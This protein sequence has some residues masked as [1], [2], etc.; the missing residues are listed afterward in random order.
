M[1]PARRPF[2]PLAAVMA[3]G[4]VVAGCGSA[5]TGSSTSLV[6]QHRLAEQVLSVMNDSGLPVMD[7]HISC[8]VE[9]DGHTVTCYGLTNDVPVDQV[10]GTFAA[11]SSTP[12]PG[13]CP[14]TLRVEV[15]TRL[16]DQVQADPCR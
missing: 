4:T 15:G 10:Q 2:A 8:E 1:R 6:A 12:P 5:P 14:G 3:A 13:S 16:V 9:P 7:D 11:H